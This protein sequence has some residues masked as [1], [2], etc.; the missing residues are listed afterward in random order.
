MNLKD[1]NRFI[2]IRAAYALN[3][4]YNYVNKKNFKELNIEVIKARIP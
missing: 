3:R 2:E 4:I 1:N